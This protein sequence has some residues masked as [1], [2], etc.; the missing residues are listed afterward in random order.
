[1]TTKRILSC[2]LAGLGLCSGVQAQTATQEWELELT[3]YL[4]AAGMDGTMA[5]GPK[6]ASVSVGSVSVGFQDLLKSLDFGFM[7][8]FEA[9]NNR[10]SLAT[11]LVYTNLGKEADLLTDAGTTAGSL[12]LDTKMLVVEAAAGYRLGG[13][14]VEALAGARRR[15][16]LSAEPHSH[17]LGRLSGV[18]LRPR[19]RAG[20]LEARHHH[21]WIRSRHGHP[22]LNRRHE[23]VDMGR[24]ITMI[25]SD[26]L[27]ALG[28][29]GLLALALA[30]GPMAA[31]EQEATPAKPP[32]EAAEPKEA[33]PKAAPRLRRVDPRADEILKKMSDLLA[34]A[35]RLALEAEESFDEVSEQAPR[36]Q[37]TNV[38]RFALERPG[39]CAA[40]ATGDTLN[41]AV[42]FD[43][44]TLSVLDKEH[45]LYMSVEMAADT[46]DAVL[47]K[48]AEDYDIVVPLSDLLY[49]DPYAI[50]KE[51]VLYGE[52]LGLHQAAGVLC[53]HLAFAQ[54]EIDWQIWIEAGDQPLP[55]KLVIT[56]V[57]E[58][59][60]PQYE[61]T[62][63]RI[64]LDPKFPED[65]F[66]FE[67]PEGAKRIEPAEMLAPK[68]PRAPAAAESKK[69][70]PR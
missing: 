14:P 32:G 35:K 41:R 34:G 7:G 23:E 59:G 26:T 19:R 36:V 54:D 6:E 24:M 68:T 61:A 12:E 31:G 40:D 67:A 27:A 17:S 44:R 52:Y 8:Q 66:R 9:R 69:E 46:V 45:N 43:G 39:R 20:D 56:Y 53:H 18:E 60:E 50:L 15:A 29:G 55:R 13:S 33:E 37:L 4:W 5:I 38:R 1:M 58:P 25:T 21:G 70:D 28:R 16:R 3:P 10:W 2:V 47:D 48:V 63:R 65:L 30:A 11:D 62:I 57:K 51:G 64:T 42:W 49:S 22:V